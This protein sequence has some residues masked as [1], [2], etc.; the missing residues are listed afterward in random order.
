MATSAPH[1]Q[2]NFKLVIDNGLPQA[3]VETVGAVDWLRCCPLCGSMH[4][5]IGMK[6]GAAYTPL[7]QTLSS[8]F[9]AELTAWH[10]LH[11]DVAQYKALR[12]VKKAA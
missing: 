5:V 7:C 9:K 12:L 3:A 4:Q 10:K 2:K 1:I 11:P 6:D 8:L